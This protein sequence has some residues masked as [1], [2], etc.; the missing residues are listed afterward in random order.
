M[1]SL[2]EPF[3]SL[4]HR[5]GP[6]GRFSKIFGPRGRPWAALGPLLAALGTLFGRLWGSMGVPWSPLARLGGARGTLLGAI[7]QE[8]HLGQPLGTHGLDGTPW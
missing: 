5:L 8:G 6:G 7:G 1:L 3:E 4:F 2:G